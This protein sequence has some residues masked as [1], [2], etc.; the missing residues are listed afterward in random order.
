MSAPKVVVAE[1]EIDT[2]PLEPGQRRMAVLVVGAMGYE[3]VEV[4]HIMMYER[5]KVTYVGIEGTDV[6]ARPASLE[7][8]RKIALDDMRA[9]AVRGG[10]TS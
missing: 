4:R 6:V 8:L 1:A 2:G 3:V 10:P 9:T 7:R 5:G